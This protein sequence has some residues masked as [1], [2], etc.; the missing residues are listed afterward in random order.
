MEDMNRINLYNATMVKVF[1]FTESSRYF[2]ATK[3][4]FLGICTRKEGVYYKG[5][6]V[7]FNHVMKDN[8]IFKKP[9]IIIFLS[10]GKQVEKHFETHE[11]AL[12]YTK[13]ITK[14]RNWITI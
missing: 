5:Y 13:S 9:S 8:I 1:D 12:D 14:N 3:K 11:Q 6:K 7:P 4:T 2:Y 10:D